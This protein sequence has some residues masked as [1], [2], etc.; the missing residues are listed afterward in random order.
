VVYEWL[1]VECQTPRWRQTRRN[2]ALPQRLVEAVLRETGHEAIAAQLVEFY[3]R[4]MSRIDLARWLE[5]L[6]AV[7]P[8][9]DAQRDAQWLWNTYVAECD[10][11]GDFSPKTRREKLRRWNLHL[12]RCHPGTAKVLPRS[13]DGGPEVGA[14]FLDPAF[15][16]I[17]PYIRFFAAVWWTDHVEVL[18]LFQGMA[19][20]NRRTSDARHARCMGAYLRPIFYMCTTLCRNRGCEPPC[21]LLPVLAATERPDCVQALAAVPRSQGRCLKPRACARARAHAHAPVS[22][23]RTS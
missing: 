5:D 8:T 23:P 18:R 1:A 6:L 4:R 11:L 13:M 17:D 2:R 20:Y 19:A 12:T 9:P 16:A 3:E 22:R 21:A 15:A 10:R 14:A 7:R